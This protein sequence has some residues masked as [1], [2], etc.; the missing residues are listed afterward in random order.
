MSNGLN[1]IETETLSEKRNRSKRDEYR[2]VMAK[3]FVQALSEKGLKWRKGWAD[4]LPKNG[5]SG[6]PYR[7]GNLLM[8]AMISADKEYRDDCWYTFNQIADRDGKY[9]PG[10]KW[11]LKKG[12][13]AAYVEFWFLHDPKDPVKKWYSFAEARRLIEDGIKKNNDFNLRS[14]YY[15]VFNGDLIEGKSS[16]LKEAGPQI[17]LDEAVAKISEGMNVPLMDSENNEAFY[18]PITDT[19]YLPRRQNF[20]NDAY[21][22]ATALHELAHATGHASRL[23]RD[24]LVDAGRENYAREELVAEIASAFMGYHLGCDTSL[25]RD[26]HKAYVQSWIQDIKEKPEALGKAITEAT[27]ASNYMELAGGLLKNQEK[28]E[29]YLAIQSEALS[30]DKDHQDL[31][32]EI[33]L[34]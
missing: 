34:S 8:L 6:H 2:D 10:E 32:S 22:N 12:S 4:N 29:A 25:V 27:K 26:S 14:R 18:R 31:E 9:H 30:V 1:R 17:L 3:M 16:S 19:I 5:I 23:N 33:C 15:A 7:G 11:I 20:E 13:K 21:Y 24:T 28:L